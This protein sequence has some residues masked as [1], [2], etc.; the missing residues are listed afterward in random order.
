MSREWAGKKRSDGWEMVCD[1]WRTCKVKSDVRDSDNDLPLEEFAAA[2]WYIAQGHGDRCPKCV[3]AEG[4]M[5]ELIV[6]RSIMGGPG[7]PHSL[8]TDLS[9]LDEFTSHEATS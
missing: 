8:M 5:A 1:N 9:G 4:G 3:L 6:S 7:A 2:G